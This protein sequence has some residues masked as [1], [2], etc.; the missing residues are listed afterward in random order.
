MY[1]KNRIDDAPRVMYLGV[2]LF[3]YTY[4]HIQI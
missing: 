3:I 2:A 1:L 4:I